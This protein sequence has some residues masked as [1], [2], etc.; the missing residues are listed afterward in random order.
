M[1]HADV[2]YQPLKS[3]PPSR[4]CTGLSLI[5]VDNDNLLVA[6][7][8]GDRRRNSARK[9]LKS[10]SVTPLLGFCAH[11]WNSSD[12]GSTAHLQRK[13]DRKIEQFELM[14]EEIEAAHV[15]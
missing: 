1:P 8:E 4:R 10:A 5:V 12:I 6:P 14:L 11:S 13:I 2:A 3:L 7:A 15:C 9:T